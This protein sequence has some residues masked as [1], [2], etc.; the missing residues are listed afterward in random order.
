MKQRQTKPKIEQEPDEKN[1]DEEE[2]DV[3]IENF[4][5]TPDVAAGLF[6]MI[7]TIGILWTVITLPFYLSYFL[8]PDHWLFPY[9]PAIILIPYYV[10]YLLTIKTE[11][12]RDKWYALLLYIISPYMYATAAVGVKLSFFSKQNIWTLLC[13]PAVLLMI[14]S[15]MFARNKI[16]NHINPAQ[17]SAWSLGLGISML[18]VIIT[19]ILTALQLDG[20]ISIMWNVV[21]VPFHLAVLCLAITAAISSGIQSQGEKVRGKTSTFASAC[22]ST[23][24][25]MA[26]LFLLFPIYGT[27][28]A[29]AYK[30]D[31]NV[32]E[33]S[34]MACFSPMYAGLV[35]EI[36]IGA[37]VGINFL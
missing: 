17:F 15:Y 9:L 3:S 14:W 36:G 26:V 13:I 1:I 5:F 6:G 30:H 34:Y 16:R 28:I 2:E 8:V 29:L 33:L 27:M 22:Y 31:F 24:Y 32:A 21:F 7:L 10:I 12:V 37:L 19:V 4:E 25:F 23:L 20:W 11:S 35:Y 18:L